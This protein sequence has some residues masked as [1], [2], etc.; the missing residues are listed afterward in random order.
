MF[1]ILWKFIAKDESR[2]AGEI[3]ESLRNIKKNILSLR[4]SSK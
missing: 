2:D 4:R 3:P 1:R